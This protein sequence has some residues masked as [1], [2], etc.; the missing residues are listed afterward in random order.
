MNLYEQTEKLEKQ[1]NDIL[2]S[3]AESKKQIRFEKKIGRL[4]EFLMTKNGKI[5][6]NELEIIEAFKNGSS[7]KKLDVLDDKFDKLVKI[8]EDKF[9]DIEELRKTIE[10]LKRNN[11]VEKDK[12]KEIVDLMKRNFED[13]QIKM[14]N[15]Y[16]YRLKQMQET[17]ANTL[18]DKLK[19]E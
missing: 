13:M 17:I 19:L 10:D 14:K 8:R 4:Y 5:S 7:D 11:E 12:H 16:D 15:D 1:N 2:K 18:Q 9:K 3:Y 6:E